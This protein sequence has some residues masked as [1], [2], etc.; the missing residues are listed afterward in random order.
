MPIQTTTVFN[1]YVRLL[2]SRLTNLRFLT[3]AY[4]GP[5][6]ATVGECRERA[7]ALRRRVLVAAGLCPEPDRTP[8][9]AR[10]GD[11][12]TLDGCTVEKVCFESRPGFLV[13]GNLYRPLKWRGKRPAI[14]SPHGHW[15]E[16]RLEHTDLASVPGRCIMLARLG[17]VVFS[18]D[19]VG[20]NDSCQLEHRPE[21]ATARRLMHYGLGLFG[22]QLWNSIRAVDFVAGLTDV[23]ANR[24]GC[25]GA[26]GG[27]TQTYYL[28]LV[29]ERIRVTVPVCM[30]SSHYQGGC[31]CE[32]GP[33]LHLDDVSTLDVVAALAPRPVLLPSVTGDWTNQTPGY[34][35]HVVRQIY[36]IYGAADRIDNIH[37][38]AG[39]NYGRDIREYMYAW[40]L[41]WLANDPKAGRRVKEP[42]LARPPL[43]A[44]RLFPDNRPPAGYKA[45]AALL[46][47]LIARATAAFQ[48][49]P[50]RAADL[51]ALKAAWMPPYRDLFG[52]A[53]PD[54]VVSIGAHMPCGE[55]PAFALYA[56]LIGR[57]GRQEQTPA[58][59]VVPRKAKK[60]APAALLVCARGKQELFDPEHAPTPLLAAFLA[61]GVRVLAIDLL[62]T[63]ET[64]PLIERMPVPLDNPLYH[65]FN[66]SLT[67]HRLQD[68]LNA[69]TALRRHDGVKRP[70]LVGTGMG[71]VM[72]LLARPLAGELAATALD[73]RGCP[74]ETE[75]FWLG[76]ALHP[77]LGRFGGARGALALGPVSPLLLAGADNALAAWARAAYELQGKGAQLRPV[78]RFDPKAVARWLS[79]NGRDTR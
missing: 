65:A 37:F 25:T 1:E 77:L 5:A 68:I 16:G 36:A 62:G 21:A 19:M 11:R 70:A 63:G 29:D 48:A 46:D 73:L 38:D 42:A 13:T 10:V 35:L 66:R 52:A 4:P 28:A 55:T 61:A 59:W 27:A 23:D 50:A 74:T 31:G 53:E 39:H 60:D 32:E 17:F 45:G 47:E 20:Y 72:A 34:D 56:R 40:F 75:A 33:F 9:H 15:K 3:T 49:A 2:D 43:E 7:E 41:R 14:L 44:L 69:L 12:T 51:R 8:L 6:A 54:E 78:P 57:H 79:S 26:S 22:L 71:A 58:L 76:E 24:L 67:A 18:Y 64:A 30:M